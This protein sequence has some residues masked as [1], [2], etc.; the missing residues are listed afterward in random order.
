MENEEVN[1]KTVG[2]P[3]QAST[4]PIKEYKF[5]YLIAGDVTYH[6]ISEPDMEA[7]TSHNA[8]IAG[9]DQGLSPK[10]LYKAV[11]ALKHVVLETYDNIEVDQVTILNL[12]PLGY[13]DRKTW[14]EEV[15]LNK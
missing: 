3:T 14:D 12:V 6:L 9:S 5:Y 1:E 13:H 4:E 7:T 11:E 10:G 15:N 2:E 8:V